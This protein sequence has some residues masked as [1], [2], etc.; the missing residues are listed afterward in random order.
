MSSAVSD[1]LATALF[2]ALLLLPAFIVDW[3]LEPVVG[4]DAAHIWGTVVLVLSII[5]AGY[6]GRRYRARKSRHGR[7]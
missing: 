4:R 1:F 2:F 7:N 5:V 6:W 3:L